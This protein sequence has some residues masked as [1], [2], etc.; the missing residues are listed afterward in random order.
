MTRND[1]RIF[2]TALGFTATVLSDVPDDKQALR[3]KSISR[4]IES[5]CLVT[6]PEALGISS[7]SVESDGDYLTLDRVIEEYKT[8]LQNE[9]SAGLP[10]GKETL[11][12]MCDRLLVRQMRRQHREAFQSSSSDDIADKILHLV[13]E[14]IAADEAGA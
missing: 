5:Y 4:L 10:Y 2:C 13:E 7:E 11:A 1:L 9:G 8:K 6:V 12:A 14:E 3:A